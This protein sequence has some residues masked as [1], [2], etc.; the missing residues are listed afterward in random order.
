M[1]TQILLPLIAVTFLTACQA[2]GPKAPPG[3]L[4]GVSVVGVARGEW[5]DP[6]TVPAPCDTAEAVIANSRDGLVQG[7][8]LVDYAEACVRRG[9][10][11]DLGQALLGYGLQ[12]IGNPREGLQVLKNLLS[13][14]DSARVLAPQGGDLARVL[15]HEARSYFYAA[16]R[17]WK[18]AT[19]DLNWAIEAQ[20]VA[21]PSVTGALLARRG[22]YRSLEGNGPAAESSFEAAAARWQGSEASSE[23]AFE[24]GLGALGGGRWSAATRDLGQAFQQ[25]GSDYR[26]TQAALF[27]YFADAVI[28]LQA[29]QGLGNARA[30]L[31]AR[32]SQ[33]PPSDLLL[34]FVELLQGR[35]GPE[36][37]LAGA[38]N[39]P[40][41][42]IEASR[43]QA[44]LFIGIYHLLRGEGDVA[45]EAWTRGL[46]TRVTTLPDYLVMQA[47]NRQFRNSSL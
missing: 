44:Y 41:Q 15:G 4:A 45:G 38:E 39:N 16:S 23:I 36:A 10:R 25:T 40:Y 2:A 28:S 46:A 37:A 6:A 26:R 14:P 20:T 12:Q 31:D 21:N 3:P 24:R 42:N 47:L 18:E 43:A 19:D 13:F 32:L 11:R 22:F 1:K 17:R 35:V 27:A 30:T 5:P 29:G 9:D 8:R 7:H 34:P 33:A